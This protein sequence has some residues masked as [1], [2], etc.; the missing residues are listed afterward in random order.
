MSQRVLITAGASGIG[1]VMAETFARDGASVWVVDNNAEALSACP[2]TWRKT[3]LDVTDEQ[4]VAALFKDL[5]SSWGSLDTLCSNAPERPSK[6][7]ALRTGE[8]ASR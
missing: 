7:T 8:P 4:G 2:E 6:K 1:R 3:C 5:K